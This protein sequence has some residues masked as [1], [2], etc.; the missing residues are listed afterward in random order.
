MKLYLVKMQSRVNDEWF[1]KVGVTNHPDVRRRFTAYGTETVQASD[2]PRFEKLKRAFRGE[3]Y[4]FAY[5]FEVLH[6]VEFASEDEAKK[7]EANILRVVAA[8]AVLPQQAFAGRTEC[9]YANE[10]QIEA[11]KTYMTDE[12]TS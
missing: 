1:F 7:A 11:I 4:I 3:T 8:Q 6:E 12:A 2:L 9:F 5:D 10:T